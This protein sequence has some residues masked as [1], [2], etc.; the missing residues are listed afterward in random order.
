M[1]FTKIALAEQKRAVWLRRREQ[2]LQEGW[3]LCPCSFSVKSLLTDIGIDHESAEGLSGYDNDVRIY[4]PV[5]VYGVWYHS[6]QPTSQYSQRWGAFKSLLGATF[7]S[8]REQELVAAELSLDSGVPKE[9]RSA[10]L[11]FVAAVNRDHVER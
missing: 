6:G 2:F 1:S 8:R 11:S 10:A 5:W 4:A 9:V 7:A 3:Y